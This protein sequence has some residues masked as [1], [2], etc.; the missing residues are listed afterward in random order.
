MHNQ[1][2]RIKK[3]TK[4]K[5]KSTN[6]LIEAETKKE[7]QIHKKSKNSRKPKNGGH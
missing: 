7:K 3:K 4:L 2:W 1:Q 6:I 5:K